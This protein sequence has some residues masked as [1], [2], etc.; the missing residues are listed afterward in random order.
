MKSDDTGDLRV[1]ADDTGADVDSG[2]HRADSNPAE[3]EAAVAMKVKVEVAAVWA[4]NTEGEAVVVCG[5]AAP[6]DRYVQLVAPGEWWLAY[7]A[8]LAACNQRDRVE[9]AAG[10]VFTWSLAELLGILDSG[11]GCTLP[12]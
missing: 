10:G 4:Y 8:A 7:D 2:T 6:G 1:H 9:L 11:G 5:N 12:A 3:T